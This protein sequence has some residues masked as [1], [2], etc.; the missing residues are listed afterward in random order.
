VRDAA[1][2]GLVKASQVCLVALAGLLGFV[3]WFSASAVAPQLASEWGLTGAAQAWLT[4][5]VQLGFVAGALLS[6]SLNLADR[7]SAR[8]LFSASALAGAAT[9]AAIPLLDGG[10]TVTIPLRFLTGVT[11]AGVY[12]PAMK[13]VASWS[14]RGRGLAIGILVGGLTLGSGVPHLLNALPLFGE[15]GMPPWRP[16]LLAASAHAVVA[17]LIVFFFVRPGP[18]LPATAPF[19]WHFA[20]K[21]ITERP[22]RLA[23]FGYLGHMWELYSMW[24]Y[25][26]FLLLASYGQAGWDPALARLAGFGS[27]A[28]GA[29][30]CLLAGILADRL[31][32]TVIAGASLAVSGT[33]CLLAGF[34]FGSPGAL[35]VICLVW[36]F[37]VVADSAQFSAAASE[38]ADPRYV[39]TTLTMQ[40]AMG[41]LLTL[42]T[43][44][45]VPL[46]IPRLGWEWIFVVL[47]PGPVF[48][49]WNMARLRSLP[50]AARMASGNR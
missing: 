24:T 6:A 32:R 37:A 36:G 4:M 46:L 9:T 41:F 47:A 12:P 11:L 19:D 39:G 30:G 48:G 34:F 5:S 1:W 15:G 18:H 22:L 27:I 35:T 17:A 43:I 29:P 33:C 7:I 38:L 21:T 44:Y 50:E 8:L 28:V 2:N 23:N 14:T 49:I 26:P 40:T 10:A 25:V 45:A 16:V 13:L 20:G 42:A 3:L 31:G